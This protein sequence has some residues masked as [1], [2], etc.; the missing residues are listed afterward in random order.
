MRPPTADVIYQDTTSQNSP[1]FCKYHELCETG[2]E[3]V[4]S[5]IKFPNEDCH[6]DSTKQYVEDPSCDQSTCAAEQTS[7]APAADQSPEQGVS[8]EDSFVRNE[9]I[10]CGRS[11][12]VKKDCHDGH[13]YESSQQDDSACDI[14]NRPDLC[15]D[16]GQA[17][18]QTPV[19]QAQPCED[20]N[21]WDPN[22]NDGTGVC[23]HKHPKTED[24]PTCKYQ[25]D[26]ADDQDTP[27]CIH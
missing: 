3:R 20:K 12:S 5:G 19:S 17:T 21:Y 27:E 23:I 22:A 26:P 24:L 8:C 25:F 6:Y 16:Q 14:N 11:S 9:C 4:C 7:P 1:T 18:S 15:G 13:E 10:G 2:G